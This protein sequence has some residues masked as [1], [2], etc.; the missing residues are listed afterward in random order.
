[1]LSGI[2]RK[3]ITL[4]PFYAI[5]QIEYCRNLAGVDFHGRKSVNTER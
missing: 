3:A 5:N 2:S 4:S 1:M